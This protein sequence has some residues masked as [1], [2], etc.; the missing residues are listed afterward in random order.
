VNTSLFLIRQKEKPR[1]F[2]FNWL[3]RC[4]YVDIPITRDCLC[5]R[6]SR[7]SPG[8]NTTCDKFNSKDPTVTTNVYTRTLI[9]ARLP[10][11]S[12]TS[13]FQHGCHNKRY[14]RLKRHIYCLFVR[15]S[16]KVEHL[17][18]Y[19]RKTGEKGKTVQGKCS[20]SKKNINSKN[21]SNSL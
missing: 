6:I 8:L 4:K 11:G 13:H 21:F 17:G 20:L 10:F 12:T 1:R 14:S 5:Q 3:R 16:C 7:Y 19:T 18:I 9:L 15:A 2:A